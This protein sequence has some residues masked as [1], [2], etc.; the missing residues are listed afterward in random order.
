M[1]S[2]HQVAQLVLYSSTSSRRYTDRAK[3]TRVI[4][5]PGP[6]WPG[7]SLNIQ[8]KH[9]IFFSNFAERISF[10]EHL[11]L[12]AESSELHL[13]LSRAHRAHFFQL[14]IRKKKAGHLK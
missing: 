11:K 3:I 6:T 7:Q 1:F 14:E 12:V 13:M 10:A 2:H 4:F 9:T 8:A 5:I